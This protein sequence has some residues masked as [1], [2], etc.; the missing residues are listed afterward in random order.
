MANC[1]LHNNPKG[2]A[3]NVQDKMLTT[4]ATYLLINIKVNLKN[5]LLIFGE[6]LPFLHF[7]FF[8]LLLPN[9]ERMPDHSLMI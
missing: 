9:K 2:V 6:M 8:S 7:K 5:V 4:S 1:D 3:K